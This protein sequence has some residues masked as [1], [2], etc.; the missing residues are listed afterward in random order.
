ML[1]ENPEQYLEQVVAVEARLAGCD[2]AGVVLLSGSSIMEQWQTSAADLTPLAS[3]NIGIGGTRIFD[4]ITYF[5]RLVRPF[6]PRALVI[7]AGSNDI[8]GVPGVSKSGEQTA[9]LALE[10]LR[11]VRTH[12]PSLPLF[13][14]SIIEAPC[15]TALFGEIRAANRLIAAFM[16]AQP[17]MHFIDCSAALLNP[18]GAPDRSLYQQDMLH[19]LPAGYARWA[20]CI[21]ASL[22]ALLLG[23]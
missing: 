11:L 15:K 7:Y 16:R 21:R 12:F 23:D 5:P 10:Y 6:N 1:G 14:V 3:V 8:N 19:L 4:H 9:A 20:A 22:F 2:L 18:A 13:Y 17:N